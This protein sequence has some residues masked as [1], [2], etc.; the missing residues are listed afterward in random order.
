MGKKLKPIKL[1]KVK[2]R[3]PGS[4]KGKVRLAPDFE[5]TPADF[6]NYK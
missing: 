1:A 2:A 3:T 6:K 5:Q 4:A